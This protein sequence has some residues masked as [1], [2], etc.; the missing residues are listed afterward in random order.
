VFNVLLQILEDGRLTDGQGRIVNFKN[1]IVIMTSNI[2]SQYF[3]QDLAAAD[4]KKTVFNE[5]RKH[6]KPEL[7]NRIDE[8]I[9]FNKLSQ[10]DIVKIVDLQLKNVQ[11]K[12]NQKNITLTVG[13]K[14]KKKISAEG[15]DAEFGARPL[16]RMIQKQIQDPLALQILQGRFKEGDKIAVDVDKKG[17]FSYEKFA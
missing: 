16:R 1:T 2:G 15:Y 3:Q 13:E 8:I 17:D 4:L 10:D 7:V 5:M 11:E 14:A 12:L 6:F 9:T